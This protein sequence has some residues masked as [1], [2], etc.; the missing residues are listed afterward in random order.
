VTNPVTEL[1]RKGMLEEREDTR[2]Q[3][4]NAHFVYCCTIGQSPEK[5]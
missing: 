3:L 2:Q 4:S 5:P 1:L